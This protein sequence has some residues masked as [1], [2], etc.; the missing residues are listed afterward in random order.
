L[1][2]KLRKIISGGQTGADR[3]AW[4]SAI[5]AGIATGGFVPVG[6]Q[7]ED[8]PIPAEYPGLT[9][10]ASPDLRIR[11]RLN[12]I[13]SDATLLFS[14]GLPAGGSRLTAQIAAEYD[15]PLLHIDLAAVPLEKGL[16]RVIEWIEANKIAV[17]NVAGP[18][19]SEDL[20]IYDAVREFLNELF[21]SL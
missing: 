2:S 21:S 5:E 16:K 3:A 6:R 7:A 15:K 13:D 20:S 17:L 1:P 8:G 12:V 10:T 9:E 11:T 18:R 19:A 14:H 4:D